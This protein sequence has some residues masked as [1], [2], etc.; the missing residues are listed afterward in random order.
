MLL[1][2]L[3]DRGK[4]M[5]DPDAE[6][7]D[8]ASICRG[9]GDEDGRTNRLPLV[10]ELRVPLRGRKAGN[11]PDRF[12]VGSKSVEGRLVTLGRSL[13]ATWT[14]GYGAVLLNGSVGGGDRARERARAEGLEESVVKGSSLR[15]TAW[16]CVLGDPMG[17]M[18]KSS[19]MMA[20]SE[21]A[22]S[23][24]FEGSA[25][26]ADRR[27]GMGSIVVGA[28]TRTADEA[29]EADTFDGYG[30]D[31]LREM[32]GWPEVLGRRSATPFPLSTDECFLDRELASLLLQGSTSRRKYLVPEARR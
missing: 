8:D 4:A 25:A 23:V 31:S 16:S 11:A 17:D 27:E 3:A 6:A 10:L 15:G 26:D 19:S 24:A 5:F 14:S 13:A 18:L 22:R 32:R 21:R 29:M 12:W 20:N 9:I 28:E 7:G 2:E 1:P 30:E